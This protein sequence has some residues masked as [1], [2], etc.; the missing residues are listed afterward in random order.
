MVL[1]VPRGLALQTLS[2]PPCELPELHL[3]PVYLSLCSA[4]WFKVDRD[5]KAS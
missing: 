3:S 1:V 5:A 4:M 2:T